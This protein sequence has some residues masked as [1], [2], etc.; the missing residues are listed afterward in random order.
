MA[1]R[2]SKGLYL[3]MSELDHVYL[4]PH[5]T[6]QV[7]C[8]ES[9]KDLPG[10]K[11]LGNVDLR[12]DGNH[13]YYR[14]P[15]GRWAPIPWDNDMMF[16]PRQHQPGY[17]DAICCLRHPAIAL[18]YRNRAREIQDLFASDKSERGGQVGQL[19]ADLGTALTPKKFSVD[20][21]RLDEARWNYHPRMNPRGAFYAKVYEGGYFG[22]QWKR[23]LV[24]TVGVP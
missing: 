21:P 20:W 10:C 9:G 15:D 13:G 12:P 14:H 1:S 18:A 2:L 8:Q 17:I 7:G 4:H 19:K 22:G 6:D 5:C 24:T 11:L 16:V 23:T 3:V